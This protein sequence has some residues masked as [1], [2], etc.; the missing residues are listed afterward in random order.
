MLLFLRVGSGAS[1]VTDVLPAVLVFGLGLSATVAPLTATVLDSVSE[2]RVGIASGINN[3][4][5][6]V[7]GLL[8]IAVLGAVISAHFGAQLDS[9]LGARPLSAPAAASAV[10]EAKEQP[11]GVPDTSEVGAGGGTADRRRLRR[12]LDLGLPPRRAARRAADDPRRDRLRRSGSRTRSGGTPRGAGD[13]PEDEPPAEGGEKL[14][15]AAHG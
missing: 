9:E 10:V 1:Y 14:G 3:G 8:A 5:S 13:V 2:R 6:R 12:R 15:L 4:V 7:A 11:L